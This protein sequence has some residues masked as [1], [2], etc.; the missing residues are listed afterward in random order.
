MV[1]MVDE[2][3]L[4]RMVV[5]NPWDDLTFVFMVVLMI[6]GMLALNIVHEFLKMVLDREICYF[7]LVLEVLI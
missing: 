3:L 7:F 6:V 1:H 5:D 4:I 2:R